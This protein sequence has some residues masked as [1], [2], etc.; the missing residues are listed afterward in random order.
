MFNRYSIEVCEFNMCKYITVTVNRCHL[1]PSG[2]KIMRSGTVGHI[3][4]KIKKCDEIMS[5]L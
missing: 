3:L 4:C 1:L 2:T 5:Q